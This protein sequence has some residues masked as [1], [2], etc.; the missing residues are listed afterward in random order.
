MTRLNV[1]LVLTVLASALVLVHSQYESRRLFM[2]MESA[3]KDA[4]RLEIE[5]DRL[6]V[7]RRA[8]ATPLRVENIA[9]QQLQMKTATPAI[10][11]YVSLS[12]K[13]SAPVT[14]VAAPSREAHP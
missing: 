3:R 8:Q 14:P 12:G 9:R 4:H 11:Q 2:A 10:T 7:E 13:A 6:L 1:L 5:R